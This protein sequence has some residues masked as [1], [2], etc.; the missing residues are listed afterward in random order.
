MAYKP[1][2][3]EAR[4]TVIGNRLNGHLQAQLRSEAKRAVR[5]HLERVQQDWGNDVRVDSSE[6]KDSILDPDAIEIAPNGLDGVVAT[7]VAHAEVNEYGSV[8][9]PA[10]PSAR[11]AAE[12]NGP[13]FE[14]DIARITRDLER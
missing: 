11:Q 2:G 10:R 4:V 9:M 13:Q 14:A 7:D 8:H 6:L 5:R 1:A 12:K 3:V